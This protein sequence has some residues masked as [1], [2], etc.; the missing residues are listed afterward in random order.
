LLL[1]QAY[2]SWPRFKHLLHLEMRELRRES[3]SMNL[4][5]S[6]IKLK[7]DIAKMM[8]EA[9]TGMP[10]AAAHYP[11][12]TDPRPN[13]KQRVRFNTFSGDRLDRETGSRG[14]PRRRSN[15]TSKNHSTSRS[16]STPRNHSKSRSE[17]SDSTSRSHSA[18][19]SRRGRRS[20]R[21]K[22]SNSVDKKRRR[23]GSATKMHKMSK[24]PPQ[25]VATPPQSTNALR[26][27]PARSL[28]EPKSRHGDGGDGTNDQLVN[29]GYDDPSEESKVETVEEPHDEDEDQT[30]TESPP[31]RILLH[32]ASGHIFNLLRKKSS[33]G[34]DE[35]KVESD[36]AADI[37]SN[38][39]Q[40][41]S[42]DS[43]IKDQ[44]MALGYT[45]NEIWEASQEVVDVRDIVAITEKIDDMRLADS[46]DDSSDD[47]SEPPVPSDA[48]ISTAESD[49]KL[50][51]VRVNSI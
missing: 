9:E 7:R 45:E 31:L 8:I 20:D 43:D 50:T 41:V 29:I 26:R 19:S 23:K 24:S 49:K 3:K 16:R 51:V 39:F 22:R 6:R 33:K 2:D 40:F 1:L 38:E 5:V 37:F 15:S 46:S 13:R 48:M 27:P 14:R 12:N 21:K 47:S 36:G 11:S 42:V 28:D 34:D 17:P 18:P 30:T 4:D 25:N 32:S 10:M 44:L 35:H